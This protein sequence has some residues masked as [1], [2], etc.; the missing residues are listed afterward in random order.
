MTVRPL[1]LVSNRGP[2]SFS[3]SPTG[4]LTA[5]RG[6]GGLVSGLAPLVHGT[7]SIWFAG[8]LSDGDREM[9]AGGVVSESQFRVRLL[10]FEPDLL[11]QAYDTICNQTL[12][13]LHHGLFDL[14]TTPVIDR[15]WWQA[16][17]S[18]R[19][20]NDAFARALI[21]DAPHGSTVAIQDYHLALVGTRL[22]AERPDIR[23]VHFTHTPFA[24]PDRFRAL[25]PT[26]GSELLEGM[27]ANHACGFHTQRW[28]D[29][30]A[31]STKTILGHTPK[32]FVS[33]LGPDPDDMN[34]VALSADCEDRFSELDERLADR[35]LI[36]RADRIELSKNLIRGFLAYEELLEDRPDIRGTVV[37][38]AF[39]YA[40]RTGV[41][42]YHR[43]RDEMTAV[44]DRINARWGTDDWTPILL[45]ESDD[46]PKSVAAL[47]RCDVL[48]VNPV[49]DG[50]NLV[51]KE[52]MLVNERDGVLLLSTEAGAWDELGSTA[53]SVDP[54]DV[55]A[56]ARALATALDMT[57]AARRSHSA[58]LNKIVRS[59]TPADW[60]AENRAAVET[61][62]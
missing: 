16:W 50:M 47:R 24:G 57:P 1:V 22:T 44:V 27:A 48:L 49:R 33:P 32:I 41:L 42:A 21:D 55:S 59:R 23:T 7:D 29:L 15:A 26:V 43:Y 9:A 39:V 60:L 62:Q 28:A 25:P 58:S 17:D 2:L 30:F 31:A 34:S 46:F 10:S 56:T 18:Y 35:R 40:S 3:R 36:A 14:A 8:A 45:D 52:G 54:F 19:R 61:D 51:A 12:W 5:R 20:Y 37:F 53:L 4:E 13:F 6:A 38:G 11:S